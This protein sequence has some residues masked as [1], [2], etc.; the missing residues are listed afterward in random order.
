MFNE[1]AK[2]IDELYKLKEAF[3]LVGHALDNLIGNAHERIVEI[4]KRVKQLEE[5]NDSRERR[6]RLNATNT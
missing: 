3:E 5:A 6:R 1:R 2:L 4:D